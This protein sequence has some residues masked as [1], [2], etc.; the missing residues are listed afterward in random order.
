M[1]ASPV[2]RFMG[3]DMAMVSD[4]DRSALSVWRGP[5]TAMKK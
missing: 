2:S 3:E 4:Y 1:A 5:G